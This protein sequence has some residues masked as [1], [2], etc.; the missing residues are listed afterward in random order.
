[1]TR[2]KINKLIILGVLFLYIIGLG[3]SFT[4]CEALVD[5][6]FETD[7]AI[8][9][10]SIKSFISLIV[11]NEKESAEMTWNDIVPN[12][13]NNVQ[14]SYPYIVA[15]Y[16]KNGDIVAKTDCYLL[17][18][19]FKSS[20]P[21]THLNND[22]KEQINNFINK[23]KGLYEAYKLDYTIV[24]GE[25]IPVAIYLR[26][27]DYNQ[28]EKITVSDYKKTHTINTSKEKYNKVSIN[29][30]LYDMDNNKI[31]RNEFKKLKK[32]IESSQMREDAKTAINNESNLPVFRESGGQLYCENGIEEYSIVKFNNQIYYILFK[33]SHNY[34][35]DAISS[36]EFNYI[37]LIQTILFGFSTV[38]FLIIANRFYSRR[39]AV[40][41]AKDAFTSAAAHELK[42]PLAIIQNQCEFILEDV[43]PE[44]N[45]EYIESIYGESLRMNNLVVKLLQY[46]RLASETKIAK[47]KINLSD[48]ANAEI[49]KYS[50][51]HSIEAN[52]MENAIVNGNYELLTLAIDN[53]LSNAVKNA[54]KVIKVSLSQVGKRY[55]LC[56]F[57]DGSSISKENEKNLWEVFYTGNNKNAN[58]NSSTGI[59]LAI[60]RQIFN[61]HKFK[62]GFKNHENGV[63]F[64]FI[65][66]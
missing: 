42:T 46:N 27:N 39:K 7:S 4:T 3:I 26:S 14:T 48:I 5:N 1:M 66:K 44:K 59:G 63:E 31:K 36:Y 15:V 37:L 11:N 8:A 49:N 18:S 57:N 29:L 34:I 30:F 60:C 10:Q 35:Y 52:I 54:D 41:V 53:Y 6:R 9:M 51:L 23:C 16:D 50:R 33:F 24:D 32:Y 58:G 38:I 65:A 43:A 2:K 28:T 25:I 55:K 21:L 17:C 56:V 47:E 12:A 45:H 22:D 20:I 19:S 61:L 40:I 64:Y 62:Y 13:C